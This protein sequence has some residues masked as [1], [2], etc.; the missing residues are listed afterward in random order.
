[1]NKHLRNHYNKDYSVIYANSIASLNDAIELKK[2]LEIPLIL[3]LH[4]LS[5][6]ID[7]FHK[8]LKNTQKYVDCFI[9]VSRAVAKNAIENF[10]V[11]GDK[12]KVVYEFVDF[13]NLK[14]RIANQPKIE[15]RK[16]DFIVCA[17]G[18]LNSRKN[19]DTFIQVARI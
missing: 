1:G 7:Y 10:G 9:C 12:V 5:L 16:D 3:H 13:E 11:S 6:T 2:R 19:P 15:K 17:S 14:D 18:T 4:E 8:D